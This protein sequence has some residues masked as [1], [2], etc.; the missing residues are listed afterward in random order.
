MFYTG[1]S[2]FYGNTN[3]RCRSINTGIQ[4]L[5][6]PSES[7]SLL[8]C[9]LTWPAIRI[10]LL[11]AYNILRIIG[12]SSLRSTCVPKTKRKVRRRRI[13]IVIS[14]LVLM[15]GHVT[16]NARSILLSPGCSNI[17]RYTFMDLYWQLVLTWS[18][19][20]S[21]RCWTPLQ[22]DLCALF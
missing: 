2:L 22:W 21:M 14:N 18:I 20:Q 11:I 9:S 10:R 12:H 13:R 15:A 17:W 4:T 3:W 6:F 16:E 19:M 1:G 5:L 8:A 7:M